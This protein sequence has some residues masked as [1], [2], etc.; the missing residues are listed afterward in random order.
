MWWLLCPLC[1]RSPRLRSSF[2]FLPVGGS[3][4]PG[5]RSAWSSGGAGLKGA[6]AHPPPQSEWHSSQY[7]AHEREP[8]RGFLHCRR[9]RGCRALQRGWLLPLHSCQ[10]LPPQRK[11]FLQGPRRQV[12]PARVATA[13]FQSVQGQGQGQNEAVSIVCVVGGGGGR[14][15][16]LLRLPLFRCFDA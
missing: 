16:S 6:S 14:L 1:A 10:Q 9:R 12:L 5:R 3:G 11:R 15:L 13:G 4:P 2:S 7:L 8:I